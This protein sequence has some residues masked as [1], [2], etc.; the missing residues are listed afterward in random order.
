MLSPPLYLLRGSKK[1]EKSSIVV[2]VEEKIRTFRGESF[3]P[4]FNHGE[5]G[6]VP[7]LDGI[8]ACGGGF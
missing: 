4:K 1:P 2:V 5:R 6:D 7:I 3:L 8:T